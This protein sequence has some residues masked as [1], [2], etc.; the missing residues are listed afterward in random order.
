MEKVI[1]KYSTLPNY[2]FQSNFVIPMPKGAEILTIQVDKKNNHPTI[3]A[4]VDINEPLEDR[5]F[6]LVGTGHT[7]IMDD[8][9]KY[10]GTYQYQNGEFVGHLFEIIES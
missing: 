4:L 9:K 1:Y 3:W 7:F 8:S 6:E 10:I 2:R 5:K